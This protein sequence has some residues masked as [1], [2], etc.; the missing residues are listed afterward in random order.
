MSISVFKRYEL[1]YV[2]TKKQYLNI[3]QEINKMLIP[4]KYGKSTI[5]SLYYD[6][7]DNLLIRR[8]IEKPEYKEK[9]RLRSYGLVSNND[10]VYLELKKKCQGVVFKR[11][12]QI[13]L[14][15]AINNKLDDSQISKE[16]K[17]F[18]NFYKPLKPKMLLLYDRTAYFG[19]DELRITFDE[20]IRYR[21]NRL[22]L[23]EGLDG[24]SLHQNDIVLMEIK[25]VKAMPLWLA[26]LLDKEKIYKTSFSKYGEAYKKEVLK[27]L[28]WEEQKIG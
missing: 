20:N 8:S 25:M 6:R 13:K 19:D 4:D 12:I 17:Y 15:D 11:R 3:I 22:A 24:N 27:K 10:F 14:K 2:L 28:Y 1:K 16:I 9:I 21:T 26:R 7:D 5:Q 23:D 18:I